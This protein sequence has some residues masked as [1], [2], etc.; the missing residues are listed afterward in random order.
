MPPKTIPK[1]A[2]KP[3]I[4]PHNKHRVITTKQAASKLAAKPNTIY[5]YFMDGCPYCVQM[6]PEWD[7]AKL[8]CPNK[9]IVEI[10][11]KF[12]DSL[13]PNLNDVRGF[14]TIFAFDKDMNKIS[15]DYARNADNFIIFITKYG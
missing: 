11:R 3:Q 15:Y 13:P 14:P 2:S 6:K 9:K 5:A 7:K 12:L 8:S 10:N 4:K 1:A